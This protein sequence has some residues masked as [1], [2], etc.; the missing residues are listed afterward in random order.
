VTAVTA[1]LVDPTMLELSGVTTGANVT[2]LGGAQGW[3]VMKGATGPTT[4][5]ATVPGATDTTTTA[6]APA[7]AAAKDAV[8]TAAEPGTGTATDA[9]TVDLAALQAELA[10]TKAALAEATAEKAKGKNPFADD[11]EDEDAKAE[12]A[13]VAIADESTRAVVRKALADARRDRETV[14]KMLDAEQERDAASIAG[15]FKHLPTGDKFAAVVKALRPLPEWAEV[16]RILDAAE[17]AVAKSATDANAV[18]GA[19]RSGGDAHDQIET[20]AKGLLAAGAAPTI[21]QARAAAYAA[22]PDLVAALRADG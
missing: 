17:T 9:S 8:T 4:E 3:I 13:L 6:P 2:Q 15:R 19:H 5:G 12:K 14:A 22:H 20:V 10:S 7:A 18:A 1:Q 16:E 11:D 21:E